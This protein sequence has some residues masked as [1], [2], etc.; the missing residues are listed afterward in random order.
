MQLCCDLCSFGD[1]H[2]LISIACSC[3]GL[4]VPSC[5][6]VLAIVTIVAEYQILLN[7][8]KFDHVHSDPRS[9]S[10]PSV[11]VLWVSTLCTLAALVGGLRVEERQSSW[12]RHFLEAVMYCSE[13]ERVK[14]V[15]ELAV[16]WDVH[17]LKLCL[18]YRADCALSP[19]STGFS[20]KYNLVF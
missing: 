1:Y 17:S 7:A 5:L 16:S 11:G 14:A 8:R 13:Y 6:S 18:Y 12:D 15:V 20:Y 19:Q 3:G 9:I 4:L 10:Q 2:L